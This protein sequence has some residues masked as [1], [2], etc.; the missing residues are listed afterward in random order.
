M[1]EEGRLRAAGPY[2]VL[3]ESAGSGE[4]ADEFQITH[5]IC[6]FTAIIAQTSLLCNVFLIF[7]YPSQL[8]QQVL[9]TFLAGNLPKKLSKLG[10][11]DERGMKKLK[12]IA[13][14]CQPS[15]FCCK[16]IWKMHDLELIRGSRLSRGSRGSPGSRGSGVRECGSDPPFH[17]RRGPG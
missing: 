8:K 9:R 10:V 13:P 6:V 5:F 3:P 4:S 7:S 14:E 11:L 16:N 15:H 2:I 1:R 12:N 17:T